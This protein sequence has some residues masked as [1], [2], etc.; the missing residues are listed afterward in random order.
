MRSLDVLKGMSRAAP[1][2]LSFGDAL[3][4]GFGLIGEIK[5]KS[6]SGGEMSAANVEAAPAAY[7]ANSA[8]R[9]VSILTNK[10]DFGMGIEDLSRIKALV[11]KPVL[12]K[13]FILETYQAYV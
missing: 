8:I 6:P 12:R 3:T 5:R 10:T 9:A 1:P 11:A 7:A 4:P 2:P 13:D